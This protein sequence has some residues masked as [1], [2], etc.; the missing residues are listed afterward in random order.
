MIESYSIKTYGNRIVKTFKRT[1]ADES[2]RQMAIEKRKKEKD[3]Q[4][5][6]GNKAENRLKQRV[7]GKDYI[8]NSVN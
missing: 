8:F 4:Y 6:K 1:Y 3:P 2:Q 7:N 5:E